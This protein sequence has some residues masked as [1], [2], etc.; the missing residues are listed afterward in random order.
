MNAG[1]EIFKNCTGYYP[2]NML[3]TTPEQVL[4]NLKIIKHMHGKL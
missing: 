2:G 3:L 4:A 1:I